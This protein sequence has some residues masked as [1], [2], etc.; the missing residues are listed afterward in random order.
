MILSNE[1]L[2]I[3][4]KAKTDAEAAALDIMKDVRMDDLAD[5]QTILSKLDEIGNVLYSN[6]L[7]N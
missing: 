5:L 2:S 4:L 1:E 7:N 6:S 3:I